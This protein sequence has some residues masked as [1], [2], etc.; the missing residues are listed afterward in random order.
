MHHCFSLMSGK[1][2]TRSGR[3]LGA[4]PASQVGCCGAELL[5][6]V[7]YAKEWF[8]NKLNDLLTYWHGKRNV[9]GVDIEDAWKCQKCFY[10]NDC[11]WRKTKAE[12][13]VQRNKLKNK[14]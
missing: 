4:P 3:V 9:Q 5:S 1:I 14:D 11:T 8:S 13:I 12:E 6:H 10:A 7:K 2:C